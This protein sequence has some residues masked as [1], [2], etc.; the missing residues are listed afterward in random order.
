MRALRPTCRAMS[1]LGLEQRAAHL[2]AAGAAPLR[3]EA[4]STARKFKRSWLEMARVLVR[5]REL[6]A[7][8]EWGY[9]DLYRYCADELHLKPRTVDKLT[10]SYGT[11]ERHAPE[12]IG[13]QSDRPGPSGEAVEYF[14]R[15]VGEHPDHKTVLDLR[16][17]VCEE[18]RP[19]QA[20][21]R[22]FNPPRS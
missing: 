18:A 1:R 11:I 22:Q 13:G 21:R 17:A 8:A 2:A 5:I 20:L 19:I 4:L 3:L 15:L 12:L 6:E 16:Q 9:P 14:A 10:A 7:Y